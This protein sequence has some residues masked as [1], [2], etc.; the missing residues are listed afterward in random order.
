MRRNHRDLA[1]ISHLA[2]GKPE[3]VAKEDKHDVTSRGHRK[4]HGPA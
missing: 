2:G 4:C 1:M 3:G